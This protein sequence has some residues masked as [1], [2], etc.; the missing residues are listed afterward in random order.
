M[1]NYWF[2]LVL[3]FLGTIAVALVIQYL[4]KISWNIFKALLLISLVLTVV[5]V[6]LYFVGLLEKFPLLNAMFLKIKE[7]IIPA[8]ERV[9]NMVKKVI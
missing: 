3:L 9:I 2:S 5:I 4:L 1:T 7:T 6:F 8:A